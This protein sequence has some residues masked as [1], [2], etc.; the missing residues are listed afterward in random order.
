RGH[1]GP[2]TA[3]AG[4]RRGIASA[5]AIDFHCC[6]ARMRPSL[7]SPDGDAPP[8]GPSAAR[9]PF[10]PRAAHLPVA[11]GVALAALVF[12][13]LRFA[14]PA[15]TASGGDPDRVRR[16]LATLLGNG[17]PHPLGSAEHERVRERLLA[18]WKELGLEPE[19]QEGWV[20]SS[21]ALALV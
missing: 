18:S 9:Q 3:G 8:R 16:D 12:A 6:P 13:V 19:V 1:R 14:P 4:A 20:A 15:A 10:A 7:R 2:R 5:P 21:D 17:A 11:L